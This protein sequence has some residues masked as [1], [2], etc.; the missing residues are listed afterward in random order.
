MCGRLTDLFIARLISTM[1][2]IKADWMRN[3]GSVYR[4]ICRYQRISAIIS[5]KS[6]FTYS[7]IYDSIRL[8]FAE[9]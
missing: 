8:S 5:K 2:L 1:E 9:V 6:I 4:E 7:F 3:S